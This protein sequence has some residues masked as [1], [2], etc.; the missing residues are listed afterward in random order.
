MNEPLN[1]IALISG[2]KDSFFS[3]LHCIKNGHKVVALGNLYPGPQRESDAEGGASA[4]GGGRREVGGKEEEE[5][6]EHDLNSFMYQTVGHTVIPLYEE[7]LGIPLYRQQIVGTAVQTGT[8]YSHA[9]GTSGSPDD[10]SW[11]SSR[12]PPHSDG[13]DET[14][15]LVPL[16]KT[17]MKE[18]PSA[19]ALSTGAILS[20]Y[21][22]TRIESV[23]LRLGLTPLSYLW[24][25]PVLPPGTQTSLL[26][27]ME[28]VGLEARIV[29]V[30]SGGLD[31]GFLWED[32]AS[33]QVVRR[34]ERSM[35][36]FGTL[37]DGGVLGEGGEFETLVVDGP[38]SL[39]K[40]RIEVGEDD[41]RIVR[42]GGGAAWLRIV[43]AKVVMREPAAE[44]WECRSPALLEER[45]SNVLNVLGANKPVHAPNIT[46]QSISLYSLDAMGDVQTESSN[47]EFSRDKTLYWTVCGRRGD[48][49]S[50]ISDEAKEAMIQ[51]RQLLQRS[52]LEP[53]AIVSTMIIL[54][55]MEDFAPFN[56]VISPPVEL[57][58]VYSLP[59]GLRSAIHEA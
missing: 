28:A 8:S 13:E 59:A 53:S 1:V 15:S 26:Q 38:R 33:G 16:L 56:K 44:E 19:N 4:G 39:F 11:A 54:R 52:S 25:Y 5:E 29:K 3:I 22:R 10:A 51:I 48:F 32:I 35:R 50:N 7:A 58:Y 40:G 55:S 2:G 36:R 20:T 46:A 18:H 47:Q 45:F 23:A 41:R 9:G 43:K 21:Q 49:K 57:I 37:G 31:E 12:R 27:D 34:V 6:E 30:S 24:K 42:E 14:E 17:I